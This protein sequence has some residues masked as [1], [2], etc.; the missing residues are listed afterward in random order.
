[1]P[2][3]LFW[4]PSTLAPPV[5]FLSHK[6][7]CLWTPKWSPGL[8]SCYT[9]LLAPTRFLDFSLLVLHLP[10]FYSHWKAE[11]YCVNH[12]PAILFSHITSSLP[13]LPPNTPSLGLESELE[14]HI[15]ILLTWAQGVEKHRLQKLVLQGGCGFRLQP[16][17]ISSSCSLGLPV[18]VTTAAA[19]PLNCP[20]S[21]R[22]TTSL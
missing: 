3:P 20:E 19:H 6:T 17:C 10:I 9:W 15:R 14:S 7:L 8:L 12:S 11:E 21:F 16:G 2:S 4:F 13:L 22:G 5:D 18:L 1:M